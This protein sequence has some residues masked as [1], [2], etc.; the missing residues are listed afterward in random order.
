MNDYCCVIT[1]NFVLGVT[2]ITNS[3]LKDPF[4]DIAQFYD[5]D[6]DGYVDDLFFYRQFVQDYPGSVLE[7]GCGTGRVLEALIDLDVNLVGIDNSVSMLEIAK[8]RLANIDLELHLAEFKNFRFK[9]KFSVILIPLGGLQ[10]VVD[11]DDVVLIFKNIKQHLN[12][13]GRLIIVIE[14]TNPELSVAGIQP[15]L[16]HWTREYVKNDLTYQ[17][18]KWVSVVNDPVHSLRD[19]TWHFDTQEA[20]GYLRRMST[21]FE[22]RSF[23]FSELSLVAQMAGLKIE[24]VWGDYDYGVFCEESERMILVFSNDI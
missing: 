10:H 3:F 21:Q 1:Q 12:K 24:N 17:V 9:E 8:N 18:T 11:I 7:L 13:N 2:I 14:S 6:L 22:L 19:V 20:S 4:A 15:V 5:L 16:E 23:S